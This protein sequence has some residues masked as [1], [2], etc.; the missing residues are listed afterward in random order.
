MIEYM[1][2]DLVELLTESRGI[3][4]DEA[5]KIVYDSEVYSK[6]SDIKTGLYRESSAYVYG[7]LQDEQ[8]FGHMVQAEL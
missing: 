5:M 3:Q 2:E 6:L 1:V 7:L 8:N 4:Y